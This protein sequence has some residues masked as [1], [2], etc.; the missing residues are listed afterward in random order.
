MGAKRS[1]WQQIKQHPVITALI[2]LVIPV[3]L[4]ILIGGYRYNWSWTGFTGDKE[5]YKT[6]YDWMQLLFIPV[7][8]AVAGF[9]FNHRERQAAECRAEAEREIEQQRTKAER[10]I[11]EDNQREAALQEYFD[12]MS[13]LLLHEKLRES[14]PKDEVRTIARVRTLSVVRRCDAD[15]KVRVLLFLY[16]SGL[17]DKNK[18][19]I[20]LCGTDLYKINLSHANL[21]GVDLSGAILRRATLGGANLSEANLSKADLCGANFNV[22]LGGFE[23]LSTIGGPEMLV[24]DSFE[25]GVEANLSGANLS[26]ADLYGSN[27]TT[28]QLAQAQTLKG[29]TMPDGKI[30]P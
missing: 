2:A 16:E 9:W 17:I 5:T 18:H 3:S 6:L 14:G 1:W 27:V 23:D 24:F 10:E 12:K 30:H 15:R 26:E 22:A 21:R 19:I 28:K 25:G 13:E 7:V 8:L 29:T 11:S 4:I 20:E